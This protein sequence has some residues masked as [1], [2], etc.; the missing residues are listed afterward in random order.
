M[1]EYLKSNLVLILSFLF[2]MAN[3]VFIAMEMYWFTAIP[4]MLVLFLLAFVAL[5]KLIWFIVFTTP[6]S[7]N[8]E[9]MAFG[10]IGMFLPTEPLMFGVMI[11]FILRLCIERNFDHKVAFHPITY[12]VYLYLI[13]VGITTL[14]STMPLVSIKFLTAKLWFIIT[15]YFIRLW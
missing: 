5:D 12:I 10:G 2:I 7:I 8:L 3:S 4:F 11:L 9:E 14:T 13:W 15:F 1:S 6:L